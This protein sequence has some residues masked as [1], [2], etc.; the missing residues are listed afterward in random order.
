MFSTLAAVLSTVN[1]VMAFFG[2]LGDPM[3]FLAA[4]STILEMP[5]SSMAVVLEG[6]GR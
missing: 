3:P 6:L 1:D 5:L 4:I 2:S